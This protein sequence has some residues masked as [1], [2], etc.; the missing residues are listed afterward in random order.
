MGWGGFLDK[1]MEKL[2][3]QGRIER[4][5]NERTAL[6]KELKEIQDRPSTMAS[7]KRESVVIRRLA[8][9]KDILCNKASD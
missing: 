2:P 9:I 5:K 8:E 7:S 6:E 4:L 3:I 1:L